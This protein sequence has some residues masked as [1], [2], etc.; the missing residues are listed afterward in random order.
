MWAF[1]LNDLKALISKIES[2]AVTLWQ[3]V[4]QAFPAAEQAAIKDLIPLA[5]QIVNDL[6]NQG[7]LTGKEI[8]AE[9]LAQIETALVK[10]GKDFII[11]LA[12]QAV[13]IAIANAG[14]Q[15]AA[16]NSG[17]MPDGNSSGS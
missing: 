15:T 8:V 5:Q 4:E 7:G 17:N 6:N 2:I 13:A 1:I 3:D 14:V 16:G 11:T 10:A 9:A 12:T